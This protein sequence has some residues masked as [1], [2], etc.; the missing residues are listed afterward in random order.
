MKVP[1]YN[2]VDFDSAYLNLRNLHDYYATSL[3][4]YPDL[5]DDKKITLIIH[6]LEV[7][8]EALYYCSKECILI[9]V[10]EHHTFAV[11]ENVDN[12]DFPNSSSENK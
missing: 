1:K 4:Y 8:I 11:P 7:A 12:I 9:E 2:K 3:K 6:E 5:I 10:T